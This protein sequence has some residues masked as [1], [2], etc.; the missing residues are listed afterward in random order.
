MSNRQV[1]FR[2]DGDTTVVLVGNAVAGYVRRSK[3]PPKGV[4]PRWQA[5]SVRG[6]ISRHWARSE[7]ILYVIDNVRPT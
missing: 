2:E 5:L 7:A 3:Y 1:E 6:S 4:R